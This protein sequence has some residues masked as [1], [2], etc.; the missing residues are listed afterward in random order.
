MKNPS[1]TEIVQDIRCRIPEP[2]WVEHPFVRFVWLE[3]DP[4]SF[5]DWNNFEPSDYS[6][7]K[8]GT[9]ER[10]RFVEPGVTYWA[11]T[12]DGVTPVFPVPLEKDK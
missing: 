3:S 8:T 5:F 7:I 12:F 10:K 6:T 4:I 9:L 11:W 2:T 1:A